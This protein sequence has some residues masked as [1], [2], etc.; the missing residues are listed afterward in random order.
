MK[1]ILNLIGIASARAG[2]VIG[3]GDKSPNRL[4]PDIVNSLQNKK[5]Y[6]KIQILIDLGNM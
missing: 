2:N 5:N 3:G 6:L 1:V 4:I